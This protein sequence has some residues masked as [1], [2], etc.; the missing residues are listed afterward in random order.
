[1]KTSLLQSLPHVYYICN[2][3]VK[4]I[5][6]QS[7]KPTQQPQNPLKPILNLAETIKIY[8][9]LILSKCSNVNKISIRHIF[10]TLTIIY[11][12]ELFN[13]SWFLKVICSRILDTLLMTSHALLKWTFNLN[14][15][16]FFT[17]FECSRLQFQVKRYE[18]ILQSIWWSNDPLSKTS[19]AP[20]CSACTTG[21]FPPAQPQ[22]LIL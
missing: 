11:N 13:T 3:P 12:G 4:L 9:V 20:P 22:S 10:W 15:Y 17:F 16:F 2:Q 18:M 7:I 1:M 6:N 14:W 5:S 21:I 8:L 19:T